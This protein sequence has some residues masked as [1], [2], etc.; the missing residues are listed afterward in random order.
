MDAATSERPV[1]ATRVFLRLLLFQAILAAAIFVPAGRIDLPLVW[2]YV[3]M[4]LV[5]GLV[6]ARAMDP[7]LRRERM[8]PGPGQDPLLRRLVMPF[9]LAHLV[10]A[11]LDARFHFSDGVP[12][13]ARAGGLALMFGA[14]CLLVWAVRVNRFFSPVVR[15]QAERG[16]HV[17]TA[18]PYRWVRHP[19]Y[20]GSLVM[21]AGSGLALGSWWAMAP[22]IVPVIMLLRRAVIEDRFL[23]RALPGYA[24]YA[25]RVRARLMPWV[26]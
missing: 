23:R 5:F 18:G 4:L 10:M 1:P 20:L 22:L 8:Q 2:A 21:C 6:G 9:F 15:I 7:E 14:Q 25:A 11:G 16:H 3:L 26:W 19:G 12:Q 24:E 17:I 13:P